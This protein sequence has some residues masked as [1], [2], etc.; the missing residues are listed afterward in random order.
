MNNQ[1]LF[2]LPAGIQAQRFNMTN[3][4]GKSQHPITGDIQEAFFIDGLFGGADRSIIFPKNGAKLIPSNY[5]NYENVEIFNNGKLEKG[6][7]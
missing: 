4:I 3:F 6:V 7:K 2:A 5:F 1:H